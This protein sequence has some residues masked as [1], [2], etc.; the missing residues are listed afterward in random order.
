MT[1]GGMNLAA[2]ILLRA[3]RAGLCLAGFVLAGTVPGAY[4]ADDSCPAYPS[5]AVFAYVCSTTSNLGDGVSITV[6]NGQATASSTGLG[7]INTAPLGDSAAQAFQNGQFGATGASGAIATTQS[8]P[9]SNTYGSGTSSATAGIGDEEFAQFTAL[10]FA[11][12]YTDISAQRIKGNV[13]VPDLHAGARGSATS[14]SAGVTAISQGVAYFSD[15]LSI[16]QF[17]YNSIVDTLRAQNKPVSPNGITVALSFEVYGSFAASPTDPSTAAGGRAEGSAAISLYNA[18]GSTSEGGSAQ[19]SSG[20]NTNTLTG[21]V[22]TVSGLLS[23]SNPLTVFVGIGV[24]GT[25]VG[26]NGVAASYD[27]NLTDTAQFLGASFFADAA[28]TIPLPDIQLG[29]ALGLDYIPADA[30]IGPAQSV[31]EPGTWALMLAGMGGLTSLGAL[32]RR[33]ALLG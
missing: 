15:V 8:E 24:D 13:V 32:R 19:L 28:E 20:V 17:Q 26:E 27:A 1:F 5:A 2:N 18:L 21:E 11:N 12:G 6:V 14:P 23:P 4:A 16:S 31:P 30:T 9:V 3:R 25:S 22:F 29:S 33:R 10:P 7:G